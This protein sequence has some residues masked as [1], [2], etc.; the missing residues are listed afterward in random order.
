MSNQEIANTCFQNLPNIKECWV[1]SDGNYHLH[2]AHG[3]EHFEKG[4]EAKEIEVL[5]NPKK[6]K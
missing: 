2:S 5:V 6:K 3:G 4:V 1:T